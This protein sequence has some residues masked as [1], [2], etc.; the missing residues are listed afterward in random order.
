[1]ANTK[2]QEVVAAETNTGLSTNVSGIEIDVED[3]EIPR[4]NVC[5]KMSQSD[6]PVGSILYDKTY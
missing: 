4:I 6:A 5:Q 3:I 1:M 2:N